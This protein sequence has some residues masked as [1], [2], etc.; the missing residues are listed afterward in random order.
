MV[1]Q[2]D[3][4]SLPAVLAGH[5]P[6]ASGLNMVR[7]LDETAARAALGPVLQATA[8]AT[9]V[10]CCAAG[11]SVSPGQGCGCGGRR[12]RPGHAWAARTW[13]RWPRWPRPGSGC[14]SGRCPPSATRRPQAPP[15]AQDTAEAVI[16]LWRRMTLAPGRLAEQVV[17]TPACGLA[18]LSPQLAR[19]ALA[20]CR[21]AARIVPELIEEAG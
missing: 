3:E 9:V 20:H 18:G 2:V 6:T 12:L 14:W 17:I 10:H 16:T 4:P 11:L 13:T 21:E 5:V 19:T 8:A 7:A 15:A 1:V